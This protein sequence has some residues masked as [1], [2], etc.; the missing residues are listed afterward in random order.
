[1]NE[2]QGAMRVA[3][4]RSAEGRQDTRMAIVDAYDPDT[5]SVKVR[6]QPS[7]VLTG[8]IPISS[9]WVGNGWGLFAAP[10]IGDMV[11]VE[12]QEGDIDAGLMVGSMFNDVDRPLPV[13]SGELWIVHKSGAF[14]KLTNDGAGEFSDAHGAMVRLNGDGTI[15]SAGEWA[16]AGSFTAT[17]D[18]KAGAISLQGHKH[19]GVQGGSNS[20]GLPL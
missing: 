6:L 7:D 19:G 5:Y 20:T 2:L 11:Q 13:P 4:M 3:A 17:G 18:V 1:M 15:S 10:S 8:W 16:H 14:F 12:C 9:S